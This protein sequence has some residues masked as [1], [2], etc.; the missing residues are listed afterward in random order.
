MAALERIMHESVRVKPDNSYSR[1]LET[2]ELGG[3]FSEGPQ[4]TSEARLGE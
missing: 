2:L 3:I 4:A 1:K